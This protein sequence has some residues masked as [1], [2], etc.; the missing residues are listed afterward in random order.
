MP[1]KYESIIAPLWRDGYHAAAR[2]IEQL[3]D[4]LQSEV[5]L[6]WMK[7][8]ARACCFDED[9]CRDHLRSLWTTYCLHYGL[10]P[11]TS[12]YDRSLEELWQVVSETEE[13]TADWSDLDSFDLFLCKDLV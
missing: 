11:D 6:D 2:L 7:Q 12:M 13:D 1:K 10:T 5:E 3:A 8:F 4:S 9:V